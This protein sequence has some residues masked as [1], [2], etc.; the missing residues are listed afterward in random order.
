MLRPEGA[1]RRCSPRACRPRPA[2]LSGKVV[3]TA[4]EAVEL[5]AQERAQGHPRPHR[6][7]PRGHRRHGTSPQG[8][9]TARGGM[10]SHAAVVARGMGKC[11]VAG[12]GALQVDYEQPACSRSA[13]VTVKR[14]ATGITLDGSTGEVML[15]AGADRSSRT[16]GRRVRPV[17][18]ELGRRV[19]PAEGPH[20]RRHPARRPGRPATSAPRASA[21]AAPS[22]CSSRAT[23]SMAVREMILAEDLEGRRRGAGQ[24][25]AAAAGRLHRHLPGDGRPAGDDPPARSAAARVPAARRRPRSRRWPTEHGRAARTTLKRPRSNRCTSSTRCS[26]TAAAASASPSRRSTRCRCGRSWRR[27]ASCQE[28][29]DRGR[30]RRS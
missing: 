18:M 14:R 6:D 16:L 10:T 1:E 23:A 21:S 24:A 12:C 4:D 26:A 8:I 20:Q 15:G 22:T 19:P 28:R 5:A 30:S 3:F 7:Q 25:P 2:R 11:C 9:L 17:S 29:R 13:D 27:P